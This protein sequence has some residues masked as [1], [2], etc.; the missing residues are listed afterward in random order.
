MDTTHTT[1][2]QPPHDPPGGDTPDVGPPGPRPAWVDAWERRIRCALLDLGLSLPA[3]WLSVGDD[4]TLRFGDLTRLPADRFVLAL[5]AVLERAGIRPRMTEP[6]QGQLEF[7]F[8]FVEVPVE[9]LE[10]A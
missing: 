6:G 5:E 9:H 10:V 4:G 7:E 2:P 3:D 8:G 1:R